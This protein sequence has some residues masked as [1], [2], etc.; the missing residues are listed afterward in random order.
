MLLKKKRRGEPEAVYT[1][2]AVCVERYEARADVSVNYLLEHPHLAFHDPDDD[3]VFEHIT[4]IVVTGTA[5]YPEER[6]RE[7][8]EFTIRGDDS[9][10]T[11]VNLKLREMQERDEHRVPKYREYRGQPLPVYRPVP[12]IA[13]MS[14]TGKQS[15]WTAWINLAPRLVS[16][17]LVMFGSGMRLYL[18]VYE[19]KRGRERW[20]RSLSLQTTDPAN[21]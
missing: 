4:Q 20:I 7:T 16:D 8:F 5:T 12:G 11:R 15:P 14:R 19:C 1:S 3:S 13:T 17:M 9:P 6:R 18:S 2:L 10:G 21:E